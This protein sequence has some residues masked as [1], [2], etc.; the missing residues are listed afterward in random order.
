MLGLC[1]SA[2]ALVVALGDSATLR[3]THSVQKTLWEEDYRVN[4][5]RVELQRA[6]VQGTGAGME[7]PPDAQLRDGAWHYQPQLQLEQV[8]LRHSRYVEPYTVCTALACARVDAWLPGLPPEAELTLR[9][10]DCGAAPSVG[11]A[12]QPL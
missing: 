8:V 9:V 6:R 11:P 10:G 4:G 3:W 1:L 2:G 12:A 7:P 5:N